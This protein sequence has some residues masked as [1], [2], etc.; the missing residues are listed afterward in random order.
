[1]MFDG[2]FVVNL[3]NIKWDNT[4]REGEGGGWFQVYVCTISRFLHGRNKF[5]SLEE[6]KLDHETS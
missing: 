4:K 2:F 5:G 6:F 1:M 3:I